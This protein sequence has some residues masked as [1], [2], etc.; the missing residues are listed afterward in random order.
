VDTDGHTDLERRS[1]LGLRW[2]TCQE[3]LATH[4][5]VYPTGL[6]GLL[7][8]LLDEGPPRPPLVLDD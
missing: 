8:R 1:V 5:T 6:G 2:W 7:R 3:L 4:E